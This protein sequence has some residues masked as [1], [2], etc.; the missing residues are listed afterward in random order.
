M[1]ETSKSGHRGLRKGRV[2]L[3]GQIYL[4]TTTTAGR[5]P[6]FADFELARV[7]ARAIATPQAVLTVLCWVLMPDHMHALVELNEGT[8]PEAVRALKARA[9]FAVNRARGT[10]GALWSRAFHDHALRHDDDMLEIA[11]YIICNPLRAGLVR[12]V[13]EY[14]FWDAVWLGGAGRG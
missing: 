9:A 4:V 12:S 6:V 14:A 3:C 10:H 2:S 8:L 1:S 11:R 5:S 13:R 7:A